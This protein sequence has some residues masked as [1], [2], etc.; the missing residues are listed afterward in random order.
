MNATNIYKIQVD[1][2]LVCP[3]VLL[4]AELKVLVIIPTDDS[5]NKTIVPRRFGGVLGFFKFAQ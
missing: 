4:Y 3:S 5:L 1:V 2:L